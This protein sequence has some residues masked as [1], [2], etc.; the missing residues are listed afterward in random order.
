[1]CIRDRFTCHFLEGLIDFRLVLDDLSK[2]GYWV[3]R[4]CYRVCFNQLIRDMLSEFLVHPPE[5]LG[6]VKILIAGGPLE[7]R[8]RDHPILIDLYWLFPKGGVF[9]APG[10]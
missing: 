10:D 8:G 7:P 6:F 4:R 9:G 2:V 5:G 1:M 3:L